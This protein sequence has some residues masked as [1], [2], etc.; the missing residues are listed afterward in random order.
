MKE[1]KV[2]DIMSKEAVVCEAST[3]VREVAKKLIENDITGM[4]V[5]KEGEV[6]G[7]VTEADVIMQ[8]AKIHVPEYINILSSFIYLEDPGEVGEELRRIL[9]IKAEELMTKKVVTIGSEESVSDLATLFER[10]HVNPV[11]VVDGDKLMGV[12]SRADLVKLLAR[13]KEGK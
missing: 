8:K 3:P 4:P 1:M 2:K 13:E 5:I 7:I 11:P 10:E 12:V 6:V 9:G